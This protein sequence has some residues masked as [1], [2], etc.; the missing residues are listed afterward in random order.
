MYWTSVKETESR[1]GAYTFGGRGDGHGKVQVTC[2]YGTKESREG[3]RSG[4]PS[5]PQRSH[6]PS[7]QEVG[8]SSPRTGPKVAMTSLPLPPSRPRGGTLLP[9]AGA[10]GVGFPEPEGRGGRGGSWFWEGRAGMTVPG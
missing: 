7:L 2:A 8:P 9:W 6:R 3:V 10:G 5:R 4:V 1:T